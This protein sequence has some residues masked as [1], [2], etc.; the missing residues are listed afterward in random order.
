MILVT[1]PIHVSPAS[2]SAATAEN[3]RWCRMDLFLCFLSFCLRW[4][5]HFAAHV[6]LHG[7][8]TLLCG[9]GRRHGDMHHHHHHHH[10]RHHHHGQI[11][12]WKRNGSSWL[13]GCAGRSLG[14]GRCRGSR[15]LYGA[16]ESNIIRGFFIFYRF[17]LSVSPNACTQPSRPPRTVQTVWW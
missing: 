6:T 12:S 8:R 1:G 15:G 17:L 16:H 14:C 3:R 2:I 10:H 4:R 9:K 11:A 5:K 7:L 13:Q